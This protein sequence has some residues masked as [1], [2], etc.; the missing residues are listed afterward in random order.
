MSPSST[1]KD[2]LSEASLAS[3]AEEDPA[4]SFL[5]AVARAPEVS[6]SMLPSPGQLLGGRYRVGARLG[7]G[8]FGT[9]FEAH[10]LGLD[11][12][13]AIK[14]LRRGDGSALWMFKKEFRALTGLRHPNLV[15]LHEL[16]AEGDR[17]FLVMERIHGV[18]LLSYGRS[19]HKDPRKLGALIEQVTRGLW[20]LHR[21]GVVHR[22]VKPSNVLVT[23]EG[24]AILLDF[25]LALGPDGGMEGGG[26]PRYM[27]PERGAN[28]GP[29]RADWYALGVVLHEILVGYGPGE[30]PAP[31]ELSATPFGELCGRLLS[32]DPARRAGAPEVFA[33]LG[34]DP[35]D[36]PMTPRL[37]F[38]GRARE[39]QRLAEAARQ[40]RARAVVVLL[41]GPSGIGKSALLAQA[42]A[43]GEAEA[44]W[45]ASKCHEQEVVPFKALDGVVDGLF[46]YLSTL[47]RGEAQDLL[48]REGAEVAVLFP[49]LMPFVRNIPGGGSSTVERR[50]RAFESVRSILL[51]L[52]ERHPVV[53]EVDDVHWAD[54]DSV[55]LLLTLLRPPAPAGLLLLLAFRSEE[56]DRSEALRSLLRALLTADYAEL[57]REEISLAP[58]SCEE[59]LE[60]ARSLLPGEAERLAAESQGLPLLIHEL[61]REGGRGRSLDELLLDRVAR[62][63][64]PAQAILRTLAVAGATDA[65]VLLEAT[66]MNEQGAEALQHLLDEGLLRYRAGQR[67]AIEPFHD[68]LREAL[69]LHL[70]AD[71]KREIHGALAAAF[72]S[73]HPDG[74]A[75][76]LHL[77]GAG[78]LAAAAEHALL[79]AAVAKASLGFERAARLLNKALALLPADDPRRTSLLAQL[80]EALGATGH[81]AAAAEACLEACRGASGAEAIR[82]RVQASEHLLSCGRI[83]D[84]LGEAK[85][86]LEALGL[87]FPESPADVLL[88][89]A[90]RQVFQHLVGID[91]PYRPES[92]RDP[93]ALLRVDACANLA[94]NFGL[95]D[96]LR[97]TYYR[98]LGLQLALALG[99]PRRVLRGLLHDATI[100]AARGRGEPSREERAM[101]AVVERI[102]PHFPEEE[103]FIHAARALTSHLHGDTRGCLEHAEQ[104]DRL[105]ATGRLAQ[106]YTSMARY[107]LLRSLFMLGQWGRFRALYPAFLDDARARKDVYTSALLRGPLAHLFALLEDR[108]EAAPLG[109]QAAWREQPDLHPTLQVSRLVVAVEVALYQGRGRDAWEACRRGWPVGRSAV[110]LWTFRSLHVE[111]LWAR[112]RALLGALHEERRTLPRALLRHELRGTIRTLETQEMPLALALA[113]SLRAGAAEPPHAAV[114]LLRAEEQVAALGLDPLRLA[115]RWRRGLLAGDNAPGEEAWR[116]WAQQGAARPEAWLRCLLPGP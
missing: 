116:V 100:L 89:L 15:R 5:Q 34:V 103:P 78:D 80:G 47:P 75:L 30:G 57:H 2:P 76:A 11:R 110:A 64:A 85:R 42:R 38:V 46:R 52:I 97:S 24:R 91:F 83:E 37:S 73:L 114:A 90:G 102:R 9:V 84:G 66:G 104:V 107:L 27:C 95:V 108:A 94:V 99:E 35:G 63:P 45:L 111:A 43:A 36:E 74:E 54:L 67:P 13:V 77:E 98:K 44:L 113:A 92:T 23:P 101:Q 26:T 20:F 28:G 70:K 106:R 60:L 87:P 62:L 25:G 68:R 93:V 39:S 112:G 61:A 58:L 1:Q 65:R 72:L 18:D 21:R 86:A 69:L 56:R 16:C 82:L 115:L 109:I 79:A 49:V 32:L 4:D 10:D 22:D 19:I 14:V 50:R 6:R 7:A 51:R 33:E 31:W 3:D 88:S 48:G 59:A 81:N 55:A 41:H 71:E 12:P 96:P 53:L 8:G 40:S 17:W 29:E 105:L